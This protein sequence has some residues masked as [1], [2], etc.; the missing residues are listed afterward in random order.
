MVKRSSSKSSVH[1]S[2]VELG[3]LGGKVGGPARDRKLSPQKKSEIARKG[4]L[5]K[6]KKS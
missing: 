3:K 4:G 1:E 5:A 6:A 2:A